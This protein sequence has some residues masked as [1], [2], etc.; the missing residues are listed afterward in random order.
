L[1]GILRCI[2]LA[3]SLAL[4]TSIAHAAPNPSISAI[5]NGVN[6]GAEGPQVNLSRLD[7]DLKQHGNMA[8]FSIEAQMVN[9]SEDEV[10]G[11]F[12]M[13][14]PKDAVLIGYALDVAGQMI[15][16]SLIDQPKPRQI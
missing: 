9:P 2:I 16:G 13:Q 3:V 4:A 6:N 5:I 12:A 8:E 7:V 15:P 14:L 11:R 10:E 1:V